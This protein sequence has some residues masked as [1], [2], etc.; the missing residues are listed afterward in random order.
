MLLALL[1]IGLVLGGP[2]WV[3]LLGGLLGIAVACF[4][5]HR[6]GTLIAAGPAVPGGHTIGPVVN[7]KRIT[8]R[9]WLVGHHFVP[10]RKG[11]RCQR[12]GCPYTKAYDSDASLRA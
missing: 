6:W 9:C 2:V 11:G 10:D 12:R 8:W 1:V 4:T 5:Y 7:G 3:P